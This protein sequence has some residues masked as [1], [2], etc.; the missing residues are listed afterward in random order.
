MVS[1][2]GSAKT[3]AKMKPNLVFPKDGNL[4]SGCSMFF[5]HLPVLILHCT[6]AAELKLD[7]TLYS[8]T[9]SSRSRWEV[10]LFVMVCDF[11]RL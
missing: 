6:R 11:S 7:R 4:K 9:A 5:S 10:F 8:V 1:K 2:D 3:E